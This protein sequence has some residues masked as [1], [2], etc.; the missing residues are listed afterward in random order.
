MFTNYSITVWCFYAI[1]YSEE[2]Y[3]NDCW[4]DIG[5]LEWF[6][7]FCLDYMIDPVRLI[8]HQC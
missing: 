8:N 1:M 6:N 3:N 5:L 4:F 2:L 7:D